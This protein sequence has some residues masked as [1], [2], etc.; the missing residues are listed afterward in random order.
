MN[1]RITRILGTAVAGFSVALLSSTIFSG[2][3]GATT[4]PGGSKDI[5]VSAGAGHPDFAADAPHLIC[6]PETLQYP[7]FYG[8]PCVPKSQN[9]QNRLH[10]GTQRPSDGTVR[11]APGTESAPPVT[12]P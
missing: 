9:P 5:A 4:N 8:I 10:A 6:S 11:P 7:F 1:R 12:A 2:D 3:A